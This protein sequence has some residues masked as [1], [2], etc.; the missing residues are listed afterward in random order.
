M[1]APLKLLMLK[2]GYSKIMLHKDMEID[3]IRAFN[4]TYYD[5]SETSLKSVTN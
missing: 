2:V 1:H 4:R 5:S 3:L